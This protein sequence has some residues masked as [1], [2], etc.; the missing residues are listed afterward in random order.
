[1]LIVAC[2]APRGPAPAPPP[3]RPT[4]V[5][6]DASAATPVAECPARSLGPTPE[7]V[8]VQTLAAAQPHLAASTPAANE[9]LMQLA[10]EHGAA[11]AVRVMRGA[12]HGSDSII[13]DIAGL[14]IT[15]KRV[16]IAKR[17]ATDI[18]VIPGPDG[19][20]TPLQST[21]E[22]LS[23]AIGHIQ[24]VSGHDVVDHFIDL[25]HGVHLLALT[26]SSPRVWKLDGDSGPI[27]GDC[28]YWWDD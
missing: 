22:K 16:V 17:V 5:A 1:M 14:F 13:Y 4:P 23:P 27:S 25:E 2:A 18:S 6:P 8:V 24:L 15:D 28:Q 20:P 19:T 21:V 7:V 3:L 12:V 9:N 26:S 11:F 10:A